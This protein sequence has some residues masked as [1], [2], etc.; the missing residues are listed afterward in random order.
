MK[1]ISRDAFIQKYGTDAIAPASQPE[2]TAPSFGSRVSEAFNARQNRA[3]DEQI[4][5]APLASKILRTGGEAA[6]FL[7]NDI[8]TAAIDSIPAPVKSFVGKEVELALNLIPSHIRKAA[9]FTGRILKT[10]ADAAMG[11][12]AQFKEKHPEA[13]KDVEAIFNISQVIP[14][15]R[16]LSL[17]GRG[18]DAIANSAKE[19]AASLFSRPANSVEDAIVQADISTTRAAREGAEAAAP[20]VSIR[21]KWIGISP[22]I[23]AR[24]AGKQDKLQ[25]YFD[26][27]HTRN[28]S[29][30]APTPYEYGAKQAQKAVDQMETLLNESGG[31]IG[32]TRQKLGTYQANIDQVAR[33][34]DSFLT[35]LGRLNLE[36]R[37]GAVRPK[38]GTITK[39]SAGDI[40]VLDGLYRDLLTVKQSPSLTNLIEYRTALDSR[41]NFA[42]RSSEASNE[43]DPFARQVRKDIATVGAEVVGKSEAAELERFS[44]FMEAYSDLK[45]Y[46]DRSAGGEYLL[47]LVLSGRGGEAR[48][49]IQ[50]IKEYTGID[51][52]DD[53]T[54]MTIA[55]DVVG[56]SRQQNLFRQDMTKAGIDV[57]SILK[58]NPTGAFSLL[59]DV[60]SKR[61]V[62]AEKTFLE[63]AQ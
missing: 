54:M 19:K 50:T 53:A 62:D 29:D 52:M 1:T 4:S 55:T 42:K 34:E 14:V 61:L 38:A 47:R 48:Q 59:W 58:G 45:S 28:N 31:K 27:A 21:E 24:I 36:I 16:M 10:E 44:N 60:V 32:T 6:G 5:D 17:V 46:T 12:Y 39:T 25:E 3:A 2:P 7:A 15:E 26:V 56:N 40:K 43:I 33:I 20:E 8:P 13:A 63:A 49:I 11:Q 22:D 18:A 41:V 23:K 37:N 51:L 57:A 9:G 30:L 35:Q